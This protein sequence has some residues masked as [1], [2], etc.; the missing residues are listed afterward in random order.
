MLTALDEAYL[1]VVAFF[2]VYG[3]VVGYSAVSGE[4]LLRQRGRV[5]Q[6]EFMFI[7]VYLVVGDPVKDV[8]CFLLDSLTFVPCLQPCYQQRQSVHCAPP[9]SPRFLVLTSQDFTQQS[10]G[11]HDPS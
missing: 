8:G 2:K 11:T 9:Y 7:S 4:L 3:R 1:I 6:F 5:V 10:P